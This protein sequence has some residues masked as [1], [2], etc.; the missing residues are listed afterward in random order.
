MI[1]KL[2]KRHLW[3]QPMLAVVTLG[4]LVL[5]MQARADIP[6]DDGRSVSTAV[7]EPL[8]LDGYTQFENLPLYGKRDGDR[9][10]RLRTTGSL[11]KPDVLVYLSPEASVKANGKRSLHRNVQLL[12]ALRGAPEQEF[13]LPQQASFEAITITLYSLA[14][15]E[16]LAEVQL[17]EGR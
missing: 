14:H 16:V 1:R 13:T 3:M 12:G 17:P 7:V 8:P 5:A 10:L 6:A 2:R 9:G 11:H 4:G 15:Q